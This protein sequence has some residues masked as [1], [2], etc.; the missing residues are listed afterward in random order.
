MKAIIVTFSLKKEAWDRVRN[1]ITRGGREPHGISLEFSEAPEPSLISPQWVKVRS[2][3]SGISTLDMGM[4][5]HQDTNAFGP[6]LSFPFVPGNENVGIV[7]EVGQ[8]VE[9]LE[10]GQRVVVDPLLSCEP[11]QVLPPCSACSAGQP[12]YCLSFATGVVGPGMLVGACRD[13]GGGWGDYFVTHKSQLRTIPSDMDTDHAVM[14]PEFARAVAAVLQNPPAPG[15]RVIIVGAGSLGLLVL[16]ALSMLGHDVRVLVVAEHSFEVKA[17]RSRSDAETAIS[18]GPG[19]AYDEVAEYVGGTVRY[20]Q[21]GRITLQ[22][23]ADLVYETT[24]NAGCVEDAMRFTGEGKR[25][26]LV[27]LKRTA[28]FDASPIWIKGV[29]VKGV[30]MSSREFYEGRM[31]H[32]LDIAIEVARRHSLPVTEMIT[33]R[34]AQ[35]DHRQAFAALESRSTSKVCKAIFQHVV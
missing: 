24:G 6:F 17:V 19:S 25:T 20:P 11:R 30:G 5:Q 14:M 21:M 15:D 34:F 31:M 7:T 28:G 29:R 2:I 13:T 4:I 35:S 10:L 22:G 12:S 16:Y 23:G 32:T 33:H 8:E 26:V 3:M 18:H 27:A 9:G 1:R